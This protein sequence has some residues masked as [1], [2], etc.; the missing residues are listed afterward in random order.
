MQRRCPEEGNESKGV[1]PGWY[2]GLQSAVP[3][4]SWGEQG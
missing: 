4:G 1:V 2:I 3:F